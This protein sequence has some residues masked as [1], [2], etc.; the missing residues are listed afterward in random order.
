MRWR[1]GTAVRADQNVIDDTAT[2]TAPAASAIT[3]KVAAS[4]AIPTRRRSLTAASMRTRNSGRR[5]RQRPRRPLF[6]LG[7][8]RLEVD[9]CPLGQRVAQLRPCRLGRGAEQPERRFRLN[10]EFDVGEP[11]ELLIAVEDGPTRNVNVRLRPR[12]NQLLRSRAL[13]RIEINRRSPEAAD[14]AW[15]TVTSTGPLPSSG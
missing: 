13:T 11:D 5:S 8:E 10:V 2:F 3:R 7:G 12:L 1:F 6:G 4:N 14:S 15:R 9:D